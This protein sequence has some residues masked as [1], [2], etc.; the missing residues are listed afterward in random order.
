MATQRRKYHSN[1]DWSKQEQNQSVFCRRW[2]WRCREI[3]IL[4]SSYNAKQCLR[5]S[6]S[7]LILHWFLYS[8]INF[9]SSINVLHNIFRRSPIIES[10]GFSPST[11][12]ISV[13]GK[14]KIDI[15]WPGI[16]LSGRFTNET[17]VLLYR[18]EKTIPFLFITNTKEKERCSNNSMRYSWTFFHHRVETSLFFGTVRHCCWDFR[19]NRSDLK[20][21][22][23]SKPSNKG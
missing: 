22:N 23:W 21:F 6:S 7:L 10:L 13:R 19:L 11:V 12:E 8:F 4:E 16:C 18:R 3:L 15:L 20:I 14:K 9:R 5:W 2:N 1:P 17:S